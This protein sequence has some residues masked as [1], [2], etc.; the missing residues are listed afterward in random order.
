LRWWIDEKNDPDLS[1]GIYIGYRM[2]DNTTIE[3]DS[4]V[5]DLDEPCDVCDMYNN[6]WPWIEDVGIREVWIDA[7]GGKTELD[8]VDQTAVIERVEHMVELQYSTNYSGTIH[9]VAEGIPWRDIESPDPGELDLDYVDLMPFVFTT[10]YMET[11]NNID[12]GKNWSPDP[13]T[14]EL[15]AGFDWDPG[16]TDPADPRYENIEKIHDYAVRGFVP[17]AFGD[18]A[19]RV[20]F[21]KMYSIGTFTD[22]EI[23]DFD[24]DGTVD[25][26]DYCL[27]YD[28]IFSTANRPDPIPDPEDPSSTIETMYHGDIDLS[29]AINSSDWFAFLNAWVAEWSGGACGC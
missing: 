8:G 10:D 20:M 14:T 29:G 24:N 13:E 16:E 12:A 4:V 9:F 19:E 7:V 1:I 15:Y 18:T 17:V 22:A 28:W 26:D 5:F 6:I 3:H 27:A 23:A 2:G 21:R 25:C 11:N